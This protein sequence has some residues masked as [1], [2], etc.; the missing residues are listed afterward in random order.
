M[1]GEIHHGS[2]ISALD[3]PDSGTPSAQ[4]HARNSSSSSTS[5][6]RPGKTKL[7][8][9]S[10][11]RKSSDTDPFNLRMS[12]GDDHSNTSSLVL[13][14]SYSPSLPSSPH[15]VPPPALV[16]PPPLAPTTP[17]SFPEWW[18]LAVIFKSWLRQQTVQAAIRMSLLVLKLLFMQQS[19]SPFAVE[20]RLFYLLVC[21]AALD[22][23]GGGLSLPVSFAL[24]ALHLS[25]IYASYHLEVL[26]RSDRSISL[27]GGLAGAKASL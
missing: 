5:H 25:V 26:C 19:C 10:L 18:R 1:S 2:R 12:D 6:S 8:P 7:R 21:L 13:R 17:P 14:K 9:T 27:N 20:P 23:I 22:L 11:T 3:T 24:T 15:R 4:W 16:P